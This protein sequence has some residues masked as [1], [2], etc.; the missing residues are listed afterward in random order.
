MYTYF[1]ANLIA[2]YVLALVSLGVTLPWGSGPYL[3]RI[4][5]VVLVIHLLETVVAF[6]YVK[7]YKGPVLHSVGLSLLYGLLHWMPLARASK[8]SKSA[9]RG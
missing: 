8:A 6:K 4:A 7:A 9:T 1:K 2:L 5:L 3:Q